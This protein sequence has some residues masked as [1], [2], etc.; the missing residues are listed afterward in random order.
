MN[1]LTILMPKNKKQ[2]KYAENRMNSFAGKR[3]QPIRRP[4]IIHDQN[5]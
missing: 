1:L 3:K 2:V 4:G 5:K